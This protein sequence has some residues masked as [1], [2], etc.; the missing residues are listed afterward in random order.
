MFYQFN[1]LGASDYF[2]VEHGQDFNFPPHLHQCFEMIFILEGE[3]QITVDDKIYT[4]RQKEALM[5]F[6]HQIHSLA[7]TNSRHVLCIFS[8]HLVQAYSARIAGKIPCDGKFSPDSYIID[9]VCNA[10]SDSSDIT[11]KGILYMLCGQFEKSATYRL[12]K[13]D[14]NNLLFK[15]FSFVETEFSGDC[16]LTH[17]AEVSGYD[18]SYLSRFFKKIVGI[19]FNEY[20]QHY[21][22]S[23]ACSLLENTTLPIIQCAAESGY[24]SLRNFNRNFKLHFGTTPIQYRNGKKA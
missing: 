1:H 22:L 4:L 11:K 21:R 14:N 12:H 5:I 20:V 23:H 8:P 16:S 7:S 15:I 13:T 24:A 2:K 10:G 19:S 17:L 3:M 9:A 6:P 18:Y